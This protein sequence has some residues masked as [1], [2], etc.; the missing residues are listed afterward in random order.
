MIE[1]IHAMCLPA[2]VILL[3]KAVLAFPVTFHFFNGIRH[4]VN[5]GFFQLT[6]ISVRLQ[7]LLFTEY[8]FPSGLGLGNVP[9]HQRRVHNWIRDDWNGC[10]VCWD[11]GPPLKLII[12]RKM[13]VYLLR[14]SI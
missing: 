3:S 1:G 13:V 12:R 8:Y 9:Y 2:A 6:L 11:I 14:E 10:V 7:R 5:N 4:L